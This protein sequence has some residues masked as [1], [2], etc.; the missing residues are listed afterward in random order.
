MNNY[1]LD[2]IRNLDSK[3]KVITFVGG[4]GKTTSI[5]QIADALKSE[6]NILITTTTHMFHP[7][8]K[9]DQVY[10]DDLPSKITHPL[11]GLFSSYDQSKDKV[12]GLS[13]DRVNKIK[14]SKVFDIILNEG[15]GSKNRPLKSYGP[16]EP[17]IPTQSDMVVIVI[18][19]DVLGRPLSD[20][21]VHRLEPFKRITG[22]N[23]GETITY[24][25][26]LKLLTHHEG[27]L[28]DLP[29][30]AQVYVLFNKTKTY[31]IDLVKISEKLFS[32]TSRYQAILSAEMSTFEI[33]D[34]VEGKD[35]D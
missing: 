15:D 4:G 9:V 14:A 7:H 26:I 30:T 35:N 16:G 11:I 24:D 8:D 34:F 19:A 13:K 3:T 18:G 28:K 17:V 33:I 22:L 2:K 29:L 27:F 20:Q 10:F 31:P 6:S 5:Y 12:K 25:A 1:L 32:L 23:D 21:V